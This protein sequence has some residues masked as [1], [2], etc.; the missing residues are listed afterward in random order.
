MVIGDWEMGIEGGIGKRVLGI[1][2]GG[3]ITN[4]PSPITFISSS[5]FG[6]A[7]LEEVVERNGVVADKVCDLGMERGEDGF[8]RR[9]ER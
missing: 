6:D 5:G 1:E 8:V 9:D 7:L 3:A 2:R 4:S